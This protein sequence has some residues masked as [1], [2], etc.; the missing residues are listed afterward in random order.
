MANALLINYEKLRISTQ[1]VLK[2]NRTIMSRVLSRSTVFNGIRL[3]PIVGVGEVRISENVGELL[4][5]A[6]KR[7]GIRVLDEDIIVVTHKIVSKAEGRVVLLESITPGSFAKKAG[8]H[9]G[10]DP[11]Q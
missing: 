10:K 11:R 5:N 8:K 4:V 7:K 3:I 1:Q 2:E 6:C 9:I